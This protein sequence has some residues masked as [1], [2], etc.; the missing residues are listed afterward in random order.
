[1]VYCQ[2]R[3]VEVLVGG[4]RNFS[5]QESVGTMTVLFYLNRTAD[6]QVK[7]TCAVNCSHLDTS[8][9]QSLFTPCVWRLPLAMVKQPS[10]AMGLAI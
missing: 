3:E 8:F 1:M 2:R 9:T 10:L 6:D 7:L 5:I 4:R